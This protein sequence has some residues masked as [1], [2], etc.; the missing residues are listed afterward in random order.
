MTRPELDLNRID[1]V[2]R[3][4]RAETEGHP[5]NENELTID[6]N[7][8]YK[9]SLESELSKKFKHEYGHGNHFA[10]P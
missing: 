2:L 8:T 9:T 6:T 4:V 3:I 5:F 1:I 7:I 10:L